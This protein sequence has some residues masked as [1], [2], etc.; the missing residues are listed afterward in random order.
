MANRF[1]LI[2]NSN[3]NQI[4]E[5][6][7]T[8]TLD[9]TGSGL[10]LTGITTLS[11][12]AQLNLGGG[13]NINTGSR[14]DILFYN[15]AGRIEK[16]SLGATGK[17]LK[18]NGTDL[19]YG[20]SGSIANVYYV[21]PSGTDASGF[22]GSVDRPFKTI[23]Y[24][25]ANIG[26]PTS[27][28]PAILFI[29]AGTYEE[30][31]LPIVVPPHTTIAGDS[32]RA[33]IIKPASGL[34]SSGSVQNNRST[35]FRMS[36]ATVLQDLVMDGMGGYTPGTPN[37]KPESATIGGVYLGFNSVSPILGKSPYIY[38]CTSFGNGATGALL[39]GG[40]HA[41]GNRSMLFHTYT[42][43]HS[44]GLGIFLKGNANAEMI[45]TFTYYCTVG[46][47]CIGGS[48]IRSLNSSNAYG[49]YA[50]YSAG[51]DAGET[52][53]TG[54]IK[55]TMLTYTNVLTTSFTNGEQITGGTSGATAYVVNVQSEPKVMYIVQK[56]GVFQASETVTGGS[57]GATANLA[58]GG[59]FESNQSGRILVTTFSTSPDAGDS[60][61]FATTDGNAFQIQ[62]VSSVTANSV[63]YHVLVFS[64]SRATP[65]ATNVQVIVRKEFSLVR[66]TGHD[67]LQVGTGGTD[68]TN[69][70]NN[71][72]Q[73]PS[74][75]DQV[76][77]NA[78]DPGRV[79]YTATDE[80]GN[81]YVGDQFKV[82]QATGNVTLDASAFNLS[83]LESLRLGSVGGLIGAAV[84]EFSTDGTMSQNSDTKVPTQKAVK[85]YVDTLDGTTPL[86]GVFTISGVSTSTIT[87]FAK[88]LNVAGVSTF[89]NNVNLLDGDRLRL[90]SSEDLQIYHDS[91]HSYIA[92]N[93]AGDLKIQASA[94]SIIIQKSDGEEMIK[95]NVDGSV[96]LYQDDVLRLNTTTTGVSIGG[97]LAVSGN[98]SI[99]GTLTYEDVTNID[100]VGV[101]TARSGLVSPNADIDDF[102]SVGSNIHFGNAG[103]AT[104]TT[105]SG[106]GA[107]LTNLNGSNI[108]SGTVP[109]ARIGTGT[110]STSTF[111]RGDGSFQVV[112]T[113]L[114]ADSSPQLGGDL[115]LNGNIISVG[116]GGANANQEHIR[117]GNDGD[118]RIYHD[119]SNSLLN[120]L[121][122]NLILQGANDIILR[123]AD[124]EVGIDINANGSVDLYHDNSKRLET[125]ASGINFL[126][127]LTT[128]SNT[129]FIISAGGS[130]TAG[131]ISLKC[132]SEDAFLAKPNG[133]VELYFDNTK[134]LETTSAGAT[135][136]G[137][138]TA[139]SFSGDG[140]ALTGT[141]G[142]LQSVQYFTSS[143]TW[144]KPSGITKI[145]VFVTGGGGGGGSHNSDDAQGGG[146]AGGTAIEMIDVS[147]VSSVSVTI[148]NGGTG[149]SGNTN[150]GGSNGG[151][152]S[153]GSYCSASGGSRPLTW[154]IGGNGG[155]GSGGDLNLRGG[156]GVCGNIDGQGNEESGGTGGSSYWGGGPFGGSTWGNRG[157]DGAPGSGGSGTH[158]GTN[159]Q[160]SNGKNGIVVV[161]EYA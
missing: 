73:N 70:P 130:G 37:F 93:G 20:D 77:T 53:N 61:Q 47:A 122:G 133:A 91:N 137:T 56:S 143:G 13:T 27:T 134:R 98:V 57:S 155:V 41:S 12:G 127:N 40:L 18:S 156:G 103:V 86:G 24:A 5:L 72:S 108:A 36:D 106:S 71:P 25:S 58:A 64:T 6:A 115:D 159:N 99:G 26:T 104:A 54:T 68:T 65:V 67:F 119:G 152:S 149:S 66:L 111:Y 62:S 35:M 51:F 154:A 132:G 7:S 150:T 52:A 153:F 14:G 96:E 139:N 105:F 39:D 87:Q 85:T 113:D 92:E 60:L 82:D 74:Q 79:Y 123:P 16:L 124:G 101:V 147:S 145:R 81:F 121:T 33:T 94:G 151:T 69:W 117:F 160:G 148:G 63:A 97:T 76:V 120:N 78:T 110:K 17:I 32:L 141:S 1:P 146:G 80:L 100:S 102:I 9:L 131:H 44:D 161:E 29:K 138:L 38:N 89:H 157:S 83:G 23:K 43:V 136:T 129:T 4:Q 28:N 15:S 107:S 128:S 30:A 75:A 2:L 50:V 34:D 95:A 135:V 45:S 31:Q 10:N 158:P 55:G 49:E 48:K 142:G 8:D 11:T 3:S 22:G 42:A 88:Q 126:G 19:V 109:V 90:G 59:S 125:T 140:S 114:V 46:F 118:L 112:N 116:D 84:G 144:T 21:S